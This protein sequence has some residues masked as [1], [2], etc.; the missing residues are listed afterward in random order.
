MPLDMQNL[1]REVVSNVLQ[2]ASAGGGD[3]KNTDLGARLEPWSC[4]RRRPPRLD[5][6]KTQSQRRA[7]A[8][9]LKG[10]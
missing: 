9:S 5:R 10:A 4:S 6:S 7:A 3:E 8:S 1:V 2:G